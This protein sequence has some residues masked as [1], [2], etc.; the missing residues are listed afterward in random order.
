ML[1]TC[2][3]YA[4]DG[5]DMIYF[6]DKI[7]IEMSPHSFK[8]I[9]KPFY[10]E[11]ITL[12]KLFHYILFTLELWDKENFFLYSLSLKLASNIIIYSIFQRL[13]ILDMCE[14][15]IITNMPLGGIRR[16]FRYEK[17]WVSMW[18][19]LSISTTIVLRCIYCKPQLKARSPSQSPLSAT[20]LLASFVRWWYLQRKYL[21]SK[22]IARRTTGPKG[23]Y[24]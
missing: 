23:Y 3:C 20:L 2:K 18:N 7:S 12:F 5:Q 15:N 21:L 4:V 13:R 22:K 8:K 9:T 10:F 17:A 11:I 6:L 19:E 24:F 1:C 14:A 16:R